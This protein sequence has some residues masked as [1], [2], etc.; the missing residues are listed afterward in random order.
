[1]VGEIASSVGAI[2]AS[3][4]NNYAEDKRAQAQRE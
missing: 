2:G 4:L 3:I 1:M